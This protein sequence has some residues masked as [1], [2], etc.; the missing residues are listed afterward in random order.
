MCMCVGLGVVMG[1]RY[2]VCATMC[3]PRV[4]MYVSVLRS[5]GY[6]YVCAMVRR[7]SYVC[8]VRV[9]GVV[10]AHSVYCV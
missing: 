2:W 10:C 7:A 8:C 6:V 3:V 9:L 5:L 4:F 1:V